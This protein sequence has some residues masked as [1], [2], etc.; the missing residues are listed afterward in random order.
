[1]AGAIKNT[2]ITPPQVIDL[3]SSENSFK[4]VTTLRKEQGLGEGSNV[5]VLVVDEYAKTATKPFTFLDNSDV[6]FGTCVHF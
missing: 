3:G 2:F 5:H 6:Y 4:V 1:M